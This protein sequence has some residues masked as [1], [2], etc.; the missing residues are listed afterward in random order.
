MSV[1]LLRYAVERDA[2]AH[3]GNLHALDHFQ[4]AGEC[5]LVA[6][7]GLA[8]SLIPHLAV[9]TLTVPTKVSIGNCFQR[10][11]LE[12]AQQTILFRHLDRP[13]Q[14]FDSNEFFVGV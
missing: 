5:G 13:T 1:L 14:Y 11:V 6:D 7:G 10:Q 3:R 12:T 8:V 2:G 4:A 9:G